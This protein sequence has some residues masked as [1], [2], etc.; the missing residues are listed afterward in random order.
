MSGLTLGLVVLTYVVAVAVLVGG[1]LWLVHSN[2][3]FKAWSRTPGGSTDA[4]SAAPSAS[5]AQWAGVEQPPESA[6]PPVPQTLVGVD[7]PLAAP[8]RSP[9]SLLSPQASAG[10]AG[11]PQPVRACRADLPVGGVRYPA[12]SPTGFHPGG[13]RG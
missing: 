7:I 8:T 12:A 9:D 13:R 6:A 10:T 5:P 3:A 2:P 4:G 1:P 11:S